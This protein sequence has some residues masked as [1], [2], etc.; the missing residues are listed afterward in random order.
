MVRVADINLQSVHA[1][2]S[3]V[4]YTVPYFVCVIVE[5]CI[6]YKSKV[7]AEHLKPMKI[8]QTN[9]YSEHLNIYRQLEL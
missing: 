3:L 7:I 2:G 5:L 6:S 1:R 4:N 9:S 8:T